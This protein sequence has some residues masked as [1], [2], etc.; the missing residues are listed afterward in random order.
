MK[1]KNILSLEVLIRKIRRLQKQG[2]KIVFTNGCF[3]LLH[4]GHVRL[5]EQC[6]RF[7]DRVVV[8]INADASVKRIKG[9]GRPIQQES[10]RAALCA[11]LKPVDW[12][13]IFKEDTPERIIR[14]LKPD[15]L[16]KGGDWKSD[17]IIGRDSVQ[18]VVRIPLVTG[19][20]SSSIIRKVMRRFSGGRHAG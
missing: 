8:G 9:K 12:V 3:D 14:V 20:S 2:K 19:R 15:V 4:I 1:R 16:V 17:E 5:L 6:R 13:V 10:D 11:S 7:G 18:R